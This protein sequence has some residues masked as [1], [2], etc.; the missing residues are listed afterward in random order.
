MGTWMSADSYIN[1]CPKWLS[2]CTS[3]KLPVGWHRGQQ[4]S[5]VIAQIGSFKAVPLH[6][7]L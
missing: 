2:G 6:V 3:C 4:V 5:M 1:M 7:L